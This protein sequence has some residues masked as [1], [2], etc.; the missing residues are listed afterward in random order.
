LGASLRLT[1]PPPPPA[2]PRLLLLG[3]L[4]VV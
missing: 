2:P 1:S 3:W 4:H